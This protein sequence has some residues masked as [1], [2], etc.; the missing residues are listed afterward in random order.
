MEKRITDFQ[1]SAQD[2]IAAKKDKLYAPIL[3]KANEGIK[4]VAKANGYT[5][6]FDTGA[7]SLLYADEADN[8]IALVKTYLKLPDL[9]PA[10]LAPKPTV[11]PQ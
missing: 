4:A 9:K 7:G 6:I 11:K 3:Q 5:Y 8:V 10:P 2:K 1:Q